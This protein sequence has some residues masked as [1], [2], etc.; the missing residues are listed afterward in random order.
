MQVNEAVLY[1]FE[2]GDGENECVMMTIE[3]DKENVLELIEEAKVLGELP[4]IDMTQIEC[5]ESVLEKYDII[6]DRYYHEE[7]E[8]IDFR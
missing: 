5:L 8:V 7:A 4:N 2:F 3:A 6:H 1:R